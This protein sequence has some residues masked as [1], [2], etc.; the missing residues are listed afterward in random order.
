MKLLARITAR[1]PV[2]NCCPH[3]DLDDDGPDTAFLPA[4]TTHNDYRGNAT[5]G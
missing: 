5:N 1:M 3:V 2:P 4:D